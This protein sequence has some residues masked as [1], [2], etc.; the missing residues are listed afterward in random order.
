M[1]KKICV[2][3]VL[4]ALLVVGMISVASADINKTS[5]KMK[6]DKDSYEFGT[7]GII[8]YEVVGDKEGI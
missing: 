4:M 1:M 3:L 5:I 7:E 2:L 6:F 8:N